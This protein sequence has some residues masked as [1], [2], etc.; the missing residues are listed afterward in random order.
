MVRLAVVLSLSLFCLYV[1][2]GINLQTLCVCVCEGA[3]HA[4]EC[5]GWE[6]Q[7]PGGGR[8]F[9]QGGSREALHRPA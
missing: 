3:G 2:L 7:G 4:V 8:T 1:L 6:S 5:A 9:L